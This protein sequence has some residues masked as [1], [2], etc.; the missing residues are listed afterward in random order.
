MPIAHR[1]EETLLVKE[2]R[3]T[4][5]Y[6][7]MGV[8]IRFIGLSKVKIL[9]YLDARNLDRVTN[10][11]VCYQGLMHVE[12]SGATLSCLSG[13]PL[14]EHQPHRRNIRIQ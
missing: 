4:I 3:E 12:L 1:T 2:G 8:V 7:C 10:N 13:R 14:L 11:L 9:T 6:N 5:C